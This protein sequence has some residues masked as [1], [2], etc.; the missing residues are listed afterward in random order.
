MSQQIVKRRSRGFICVNAHPEGCRKNV[1]RWIDGVR[2]KIPSGQTGPKNV[3]VIGASTGYGLASRIAAASGCG[4]KTLGVFFERPPEGEKVATA[5]YYNTVALH[6]LAKQD[7]LFAASIN[8]DAFSDDIKRASAEVLRS[9]MGPVDLVIYSLASPKR[10]DPRTGVV[11][12]SVLK[13]VGQAYTN[14]TIELDTEKVVNVTLQPANEDE[15][16]DTVAVMGGD[17]WRRWMEMLLEEKLLAEGARTLAYSYIGPELTWPIYRDGTIGQAKKDLERAASDLDA[18]LAKKLGGN[19]WVSVNKAVVTQ[20]SA[21]I[22]VVPLYLS[23]LPM[24]MKKKNLEEG[25]LEQMRRMFSDF[26]CSAQPMK[27]DASR[28]LRLDDREMRADVQAEVAALWPQVGTENLRAI[29]DFAGF[30]REFRGLFGFEVDG[31]DYEQPTETD[32]KW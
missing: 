8:G 22:P 5:G 24:I 31:V 32:L 30:Q 16:A 4:A 15:I 3:L 13:P 2:G 10:T 1:E 28:R 29:T 27:L 19:A 11:Y 26:L 18:A 9:Q 12:N 25:P 14:R 21:A 17:D 20:A 6:A 23:L 7:G